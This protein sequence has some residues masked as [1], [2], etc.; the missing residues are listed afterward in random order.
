MAL[1]AVRSESAG[2]E[3]QEFLDRYYDACRKG[4]LEQILSFLS[5]DVVAYDMPPVFRFKGRDDY[6]TSW[7][8]WFI[9]DFEF[10]VNVET[11]EEE[12]F[13]DGDLAL[14]FGLFKIEGKFKKTGENMGCWMRHSTGLRKA[15]GKWAI[16]H[17]HVSV[18]VAMDG[19]AMMDVDA[20]K[21]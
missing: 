3:V 20:T 21:L 12:I 13:V 16:I 11:R 2:R 7:E 8:R 4:D 5:P 1:A 14:A 19:K 17:E 15:G 9:S 6:K 18:P 10:P